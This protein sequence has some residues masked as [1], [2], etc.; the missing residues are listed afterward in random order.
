MFARVFGS[1][2]AGGGRRLGP[3]SRLLNAGIL[4]VREEKRE[5]GG[6]EEITNVVEAWAG[7]CTSCFEKCVP[8]RFKCLPCST[9]PFTPKIPS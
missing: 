6:R 8:I 9:T 2:E 7:Y 4:V 1:C 5:Q 3:R